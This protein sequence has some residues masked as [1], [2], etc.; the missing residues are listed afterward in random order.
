MT[1]E[2]GTPQTKDVWPGSCQATFRIGNESKERWALDT[3][4]RPPHA[5]SWCA[6]C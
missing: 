6:R 1:E 5:L 2:K 4:R 3:Q